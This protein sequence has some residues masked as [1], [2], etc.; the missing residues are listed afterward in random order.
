VLE[1]DGRLPGRE[2]LIFSC[3]KSGEAKEAG[4]GI[5]GMSD[6]AEDL[7]YCPNCGI[8]KIARFCAGCGFDFQLGLSSLDEAESAPVSEELESAAPEP[9]P[10]ATVEPEAEPVPEST[11]ALEDVAS[12]EAPVEVPD[13]I[14]PVLEAVAEAIPQPAVIAEQPAPVVSEPV[15]QEIPVI[16]PIPEPVE[17]PESGWYQD[18]LS[19]AQF[20]YWN[21]YSWTERVATSALAGEEPAKPKKQKSS[22]SQDQGILD[23]KRSSIIL[24]GLK[25]GPN[26]NQSNSCYNCG[27]KT[28]TSP[29]RCDL[30]AA[31]LEV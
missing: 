27:Y 19:L 30:C 26:F 31:A 10:E 13:P 23:Q 18:P 15:A 6:V 25:R 8:E 3:R 21:D 4:Q 20:R 1:R 14:E 9:E 16:E 11:P 7:K 5:A 28:S 24:E 2:L 12:V 22:A 17:L 29:S